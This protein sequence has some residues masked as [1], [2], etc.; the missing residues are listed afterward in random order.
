MSKFII[1]NILFIMIYSISKDYP[2][3]LS[4][5]LDKLLVFATKHSIIFLPRKLFFI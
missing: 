4:K 3:E 2:T 1:L 5:D